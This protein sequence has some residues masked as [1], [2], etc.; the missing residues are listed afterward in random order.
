[1]LI[2]PE[3][4]TRN[5]AGTRFCTNCGA[6]LEWEAAPSPAPVPP[7]RPAPGP[8]PEPELQRSQHNRDRSGQ[9]DGTDRRRIPHNPD[10]VRKLPPDALP[11]RPEGPGKDDRTTVL[12]RV[13]DQESH[14]RAPH[15]PG[16][17]PP[18]PP[19]ESRPRPPRPP[20]EEPETPPAPGEIVCPRCGAGNPPDRHFCRRCALDLSRALAPPPPQPVGQSRPHRKGLSPLLW[21]LIVLVV[22]V[23]VYLLYA[24]FAAS[25][26][27]GPLGHDD[28]AGRTWHQSSTPPGV[29]PG[30]D[31]Q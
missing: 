15:R 11:D 25:A 5:A 27:E 9:D 13:P 23:A 21:G 7:P 4:G 17:P 3:C 6:Y 29:G 24:G 14:P 19:E 18:V 26:A 8:S 1:M 20:D 2:C 30:I 10:K 28:P 22:L 12:P 16:D 31:A